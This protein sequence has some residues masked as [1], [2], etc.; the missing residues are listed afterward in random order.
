MKKISP[1]NDKTDISPHKIK[2]TDFTYQKSVSSLKCS[3]MFK[4][5]YP[6]TNIYTHKVN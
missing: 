6:H 3:R 1:H 2:A 4:E 5:T